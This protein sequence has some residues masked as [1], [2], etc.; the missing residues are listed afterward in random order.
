MKQIPTVKLLAKK[1]HTVLKYEESLYLLLFQFVFPL[2]H[3]IFILILRVIS[4]VVRV[5]A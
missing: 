4:S 3:S 2:L 5:N 1:C